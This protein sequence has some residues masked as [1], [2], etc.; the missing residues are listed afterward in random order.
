MEKIELSYFSFCRNDRT[1]PQLQQDRD[2]V[3]FQRH[4][5]HI[6]GS[7]ESEEEDPSEVESKD[8]EY[9]IMT[10]EIDYKE[11]ERPIQKEKSMKGN[12]TLE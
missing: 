1:D 7:E 6:K 5:Q 4:K 3:F 11:E 2:K 12:E 8:K 10:I 9:P